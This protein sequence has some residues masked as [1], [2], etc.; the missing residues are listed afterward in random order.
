MPILSQINPSHATPSHG[1][2]IY[3]NNIPFTPRFFN[4]SLSLTFPHENP[5]GTSPSRY[6]LHS[7]PISLFLIWS[8]EYC[9]VRGTDNKATNYAIFSSPLLHHLRAL[10]S[11]T[12]CHVSPSVWESQVSH[13]YKTASKIVCLYILTFYIFNRKL[14]DNL[15]RIIAVIFW[16]QSAHNFFYKKKTVF[17]DVTSYNVVKT[18]RICRQCA[19]LEYVTDRITWNFI[20]VKK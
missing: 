16:V 19:A 5:V 10:F 8:P 1:L 15:H 13:R 11:N 3:F 4:R 7:L 20:N 17:S 2:K 6:V 9:F 18:C 12:C 14:E